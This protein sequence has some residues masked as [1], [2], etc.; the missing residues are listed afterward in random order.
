[1][2]ANTQLALTAAVATWL[3][4]LAA[5][6]LELEIPWWS[7]LSAWIVISADR[8]QVLVKGCLQVT[9]T[10]LAAVIGYVIAVRI[11][12]FILLQLLFIVFFASL[13][14]YMRHTSKA[15][16]A[17]LLGTLMVLTLLVESIVNPTAIEIVAIYRCYELLT[18]TIVAA[19]VAATVATWQERKNTAGAPASVAPPLAPPQDERRIAHVSLFGGV[20]TAVILIVWDAFD[21]PSV[22]PVLIS[23]LIVISPD[24]A[25]MRRTAVDRALGCLVGGGAGILVVSFGSES[26]WIWSLVLLAG[27]FLAGTVHLSG[28]PHA[29]VG[30]LAGVAFI[31]AM[32]GSG[33]PQ[34]DLLNVIRGGRAR[35][36]LE[37]C[38][39]GGTAEGG[40]AR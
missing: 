36:V 33:G 1:M 23:A 8:H 9:G 5:F 30:T 37:R 20:A 26:I 16:F 6:A 2:T 7:G 29:A 3:A 17:W 12:G 35:G 13:G 19:L 40:A 38:A 22:V 25:G 4:I 14:I 34:T 27:L 32:V 11:E 39:S 10:V 31:I 18:G 28:K 21:I 15:A 24:I